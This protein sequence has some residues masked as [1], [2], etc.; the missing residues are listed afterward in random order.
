MVQLPI[1]WL[2][3]CNYSLKIQGFDDA[4]K[5]R[6][7]VQRIQNIGIEEFYSPKKELIKTCVAFANTTGGKIIIG[8]EDGTGKII[9]VT[10]KVRDKIFEEV[11]NSMYDSIAP[12]VIPEIFEKNVNG[13]SI[14][15]IKIYPG[16]KT[17]YFVKS[18]GNKNGVYL[19]VGSSTRR[20]SE[21]YIEDLY[22][23]Q[24]N[25]HYDESPSAIFFE[26]LG[27][28]EIPNRCWQQMQVFYFLLKTLMNIFLNQLLFALN[29]K[30]ELEEI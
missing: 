19:R 16:N 6:S 1:G 2:N 17:P 15:F 13:K 30:G 12:I 26:Q 4:Q 23:Q 8:V 20:A 29:L 5:C 21:E 22:R 11:S 25:I 28:K 24:K 10:D 3:W 27:R 9:G 14:I 18:E 7:E